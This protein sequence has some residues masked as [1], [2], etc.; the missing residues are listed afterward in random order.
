MR[1]RIRDPETFWPW[2]GKIRIRIRN[3]DYGTY[4]FTEFVGPL[5]WIVGCGKWTGKG[6]GLCCPLQPWATVVL[7]VVAVNI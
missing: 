3:T 5:F 7:Q 1:I 4:F 2:M 6:E